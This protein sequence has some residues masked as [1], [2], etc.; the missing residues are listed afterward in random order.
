M[1]EIV[2]A[3]TREQLEAVAGLFRHYADSLDFDLG[4]QGFA[5]ELAGLP[6]DYGPPR[7]RL[8]LA[9]H[10]GRVAGCVAL[11]ELADGRCEMKRLYVRPEFQGLGIGRALARAVIEEA[12]TIGYVAMRLDT[13]PSMARARTLYAALGFREIAPYRHNPLKGAAFLELTL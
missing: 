12:R 2:Q 9:M 5:E 7:G 3:Q 11:R 8:L 13:A 1:P 6:G 10:R 4:F